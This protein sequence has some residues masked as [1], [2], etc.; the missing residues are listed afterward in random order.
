MPVIGIVCSAV[1]LGERIG[2][3]LVGALALILGGIAL[4]MVRG[5]G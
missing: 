2:L 5:K 3:A 1:S 4:G